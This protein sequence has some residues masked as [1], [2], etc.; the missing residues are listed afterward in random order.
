M[1]ERIVRPLILILVSLIII[2]FSPTNAGGAPSEPKEIREAVQS[3]EQQLKK[4]S[5]AKIADEA[6]MSTFEILLLILTSIYVA[7]TLLL[8]KTTHSQVRRA[9]DQ[10]RL[11]TDSL[12]LTR[13]S[14]E[15]TKRAV[16]GS[17][18]QGIAINHREIAFKALGCTLLMRTFMPADIAD[19]PMESLNAETRL[20]ATVLINHAETCFE[21][22]R[23]K[24]IPPE[25]AGPLLS[26]IEGM[27]ALHAIQLRWKESRNRVEEEF[28]KFGDE[29]LQKQQ[30]KPQEKGG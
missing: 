5:V 30:Q 28:R 23:F 8:W 6:C 14:L 19:Q 20:F 10:V 21:H 25:F 11:T 12:N 18:L 3:I 29:A 1:R 24:T 7:G 22:V 27:F 17:R 4:I 2:S 13:E 9:T 15:A 26:D 16:Y